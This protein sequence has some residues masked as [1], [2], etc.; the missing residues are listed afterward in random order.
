MPKTSKNYRLSAVGLKP[1]AKDDPQRAGRTLPA[2]S[3]P[4]R[5][6]KPPGAV[7]RFLA[8]AG[9]KGGLAR[10]KNLTAEQLSAIGRKARSAQLSR[11]RARVE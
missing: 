6:S 9:R 4:A 1:T 3:L 2:T 10:A 5:R 8:E 7:S 11:Q